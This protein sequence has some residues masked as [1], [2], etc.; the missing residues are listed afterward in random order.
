MDLPIWAL[1]MKKNYEDPDL[2]VSKEE[3]QAPEN[4]TINLDCSKVIQAVGEEDDLKDDL[5]LDF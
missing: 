4:M 5:E 1:Y 2:G 3:F